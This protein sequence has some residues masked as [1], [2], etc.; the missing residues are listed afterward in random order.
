MNFDLDY[1][2]KKN[3]IDSDEISILNKRFD[4]IKSKKT[5]ASV[6]KNISELSAQE[7]YMEPAFDNINKI[8][9][10][11]FV[12]NLGLKNLQLTKLWLVSTTHS[13]VNPSQLPYVPHFDKL[14]YFKVMVYLHTITTDHGPIHLGKINNEIDIEKRRKKLPDDYKVHGLNI[15]DEQ[16]L[17]EGLTPLIGEAGDVIFFDTNIPHKAGILTVGYERRVLRFDFELPGLN[18]QPTLLR[19]IIK[20]Y[21]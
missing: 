8:I 1:H 7:T 6:H 20:K 2:V 15:I 5:Y 19:R 13:D 17:R 11:Y 21:F 16:D 9:R 3:F 18:P 12:E 10:E 4:D 14:R